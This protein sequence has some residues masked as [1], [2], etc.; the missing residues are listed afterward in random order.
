MLPDDEESR[1]LKNIF[2]QVSSDME[3]DLSMRY[4]GGENAH[5]VEERTREALHQLMMKDRPDDEH[6]A[7]VG[8]GRSNRILLA[9]SLLFNDASKFASIEQGN[10][11]ISIVDYDPSD[12][13]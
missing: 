12:D 9:S 8:H 3:G 4:P 1:R 10:T 2:D 13:K 5:E 7:V 11:A 6:V